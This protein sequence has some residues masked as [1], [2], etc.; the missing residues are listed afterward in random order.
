MGDSTPP[1]DAAARRR[2]DAAL[3]A[4]LHQGQA[5]HESARAQKLVD[6][7]VAEARR[8]AIATQPLV[9]STLDGHTVKT[10]KVGWYIRAN[11]S[12]AV[13]DDGQYYVLTVPAGFMARLRGVKLEPSP[14]PLVVGRG[15]RDGDSG[16][17]SSFLAWRLEQG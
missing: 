1:P 8:R 9:A 14:P 5:L 15:G 2:E 13:G 3:R 12:V 7:F 10:D 6:E 4:R 16:D 17:L 11:R